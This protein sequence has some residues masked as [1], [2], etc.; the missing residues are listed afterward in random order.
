MDMKLEAKLQKVQK[1]LYFWIWGS[2][3]ANDIL[4]ILMAFIN[5][6]ILNILFFGCWVI[7]SSKTIVVTTEHWSLIAN[8]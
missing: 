6:F 4:I 8:K 7:S 1:L 5:H 3:W 2:S